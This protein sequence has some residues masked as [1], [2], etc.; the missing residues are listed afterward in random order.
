MTAKIAI[1]AADYYESALE[2]ARKPIESCRNRFPKASYTG[3]DHLDFTSILTSDIQLWMVQLEVKALWLNA[4]AHY[5][6]PPMSGPQDEREDPSI[7][8]ERVTRLD[9]ALKLMSKALKLCK[10]EISG[11]LLETISVSCKHGK[12]APKVS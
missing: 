8:G 5:H 11:S 4:M 3:H 9:I 1:Q 6:C 2:A 7:V 10:N 12:N